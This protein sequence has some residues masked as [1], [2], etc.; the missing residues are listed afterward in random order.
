MKENHILKTYAG[1]AFVGTRTVFQGYDLHKDLKDSN[2]VALYLLSITG[3][4]LSPKEIELIQ[5]I[6]VCT[7]YPDVR[8]WNNRVAGLAGSAR[9]TPSL[10]MAAA[11]AMSEATVYGGHPCTRISDFLQKAQKRLNDGDQL[12][13]IVEQELAIRRI[14]GY[15]RPINNTDE[16][17]Q[18]ISG[19]AKELNLDTGPHYK[20]SFEI[21]RILVSKKSVLK[22][23]YAAIVAGLF[24]DIGLTVEQIKLVIYPMLSAGM[25]P[26][27]IEAASNP[28]N[29]LFQLDCTDIR[30]EGVSKRSWTPL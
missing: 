11:C 5:A 9:S 13:D 26:C 24:L 28:E 22:M 8:L 14:Y 16:R 29:E 19:I 12:S 18:W 30:Y 7:S 20:L 2:W 17:L 21:E 6:W 27:Y 3:R 15:G 4:K 23:N 10:G 1:K 25:P